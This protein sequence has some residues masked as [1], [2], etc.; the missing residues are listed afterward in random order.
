MAYVY[1][2]NGRGSNNK[3]HWNGSTNTGTR[4]EDVPI[5]LRRTLP[6]GDL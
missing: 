1:G 2:Q 6:K 4:I 5:E 3:Y